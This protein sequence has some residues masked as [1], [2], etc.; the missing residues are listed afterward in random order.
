MAHRLSRFSALIERIYE[1]ALQPARWADIPQPVAELHSSPQS[2]LFAVRRT[3]RE[4][5]FA[6]PFGITSS[7]MET[8]ASGTAQDNIWVINGFKK[9]LFVRGNVVRDRDLASDEELLASDYYQ[10]FLKPQD[11]RYL[12][13]GIVFDGTDGLPPTIC[14]VIRGHRHK[15]FSAAHVRTHK[16]I[17]DHISK[18][19]G[20]MWRL[21]AKDMKIAS[22]QAALDLLGTA[23]ILLGANGTVGFVNRAGRE[24]LKAADGIALRA[25][26]SGDRLVVDSPREQALLEHML[27]QTVASN[28]VAGSGHFSEG[29]RISRSSGHPDLVLQLAPL[30]ESNAFGPDEYR[31]VCFLT[32]LMASGR[33]D[34]S[35]LRAMFELS[36]A[37][38][39]LA[40][41]LLSG[42]SVAQIAQRLGVSAR[43]LR[44]QLA[45]IFDKTGARRQ[46]QL[47]KLL[48]SLRAR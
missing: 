27:A 26:A 14:S 16:L 2:I 11:S 25:T 20:S 21:R 47:M 18:A 44:F 43:T 38:V 34:E 13:S 12:L 42:D 9:G 22:T 29:M 7:A 35:M 17:T 8:W 5:G 30:A 48:M 36:P 4:E 40:E 19:M 24:L 10:R 32:D 45:S 1:A 39:R 6:Y 46:A 41:E 23:V 33:L 37:E 15:P 3:G 28:R 31:A